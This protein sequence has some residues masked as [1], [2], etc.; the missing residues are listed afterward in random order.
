MVLTTVAVNKNAWD[1]A[2]FVMRGM[3]GGGAKE[4]PIEFDI[5]PSDY[6]DDERME[7]CA[8]EMMRSAFRFSSY[9]FT[10]PSL[11]IPH[12]WDHTQSV[13]SDW[14]LQS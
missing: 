2:S 7:V 8:P 1:A 3:P 6:A 11:G 13:G 9:C 10:A 4:C 5:A 12:F 14:I